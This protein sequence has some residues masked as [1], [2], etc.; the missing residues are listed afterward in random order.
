MW[1]ERVRLIP[2]VSVKDN[3]II[4]KS[5]GCE[6]YFFVITQDFPSRFFR[7]ALSVEPKKAI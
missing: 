4:E 7:F 6:K 3:K 2:N 5:V 1:N